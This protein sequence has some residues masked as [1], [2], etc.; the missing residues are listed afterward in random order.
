MSMKPFI[1]LHVHSPFSFLDG[2]S[3]L[4]ALI[5]RAAQLE[6]PA[7]ALTDH[8]NLHG[9]VQFQQL[10]QKA[11]IK[12][13]LGVEMTLEGDYHLTLLAQGPA[14]YATLCT[15]LTKA[16]LAHPRGQPRLK[17]ELLWEHNRGLICLSG[18]RQGL[19]PRLIMEGNFQEAYRI[20]CRFRDRLEFFYLELPNPL[21]PGG[22]RLNS[23][24][25]QLGEEAKIPLVA[26]NN[27]HYAC[28]EDFPLHDV[29]T[30][31]RTKTTLEA[32]HPQ[33]KLNGENYLQST[34]EMALLFPSEALVNTWEIGCR[35]QPALDLSKK[36]FPR[37][38]DF[39]GD[40][41][42]ELV[43]A[44]AQRRY[45][46]ITPQISRRLRHELDIIKQLDVADY[47]LIVWDVAQ[48]ARREGIRYSG[49]G[50]AADSA[51][52]YCLGIT[53]V[54]AIG[55]GLLFERFLSLERAQTPDIDLDFDA[56][57]RDQI[58]D[59]V[60]TKF[61]E[62]F[63]A[64]VCT[65]QTFRARSAVREVGAALGWPPSE[66]QRLAKAL[67]HIPADALRDAP[68]RYPELRR[69]PWSR[70]EKLVSLC[71]RI[72]GFPR[73]VGTHLGGLIIGDLPLMELTPLQ[74]SAKGV[75]ITQYDKDDCEALGFIKL[76]LLSLRTLSA[77]EDTVQAI[78]LREEKFDYSQIPMDDSQTFQMIREGET[79]GVFQLESPA[80]RSLQTRLGADGLEDIIASVALIRPG[81]IKA[82]MVEPFVARRHG[83]EK[84]DYLHPLLE[85]IL[86]KTYG[87][88]LFQ[89]Q[90]IEIAIEVAG[91]TPGEADHLRKIMGK[92]RTKG[93]LDNLRELFITK[94]RQRGLT[95]TRA[96]EIFEYIAAYA[97]YGFCEAHA[98][99]FANLAYKTA[100]LAAHY[101]AEFFAAL[102]SHQPMG[103]YPPQTI[104]L[105]AKRRGIKLLPVDVNFSQGDFFP[106][107]KTI[108]L[109]LRQVKE[110]S[111]EGVAAILE[112]RREGPFTDLPDLVRRT[113]LPRN[114][115]TNLILCGALD[116]LHP[117]RKAL[118]WQLQRLP[119]GGL[120]WA[121]PLPQIE[122]FSPYQKFLYEYSL[123]G[124]SC[125]GHIL[126][127]LRPELKKKGYL[128]H[129]D[130]PTLAAGTKV[131]IA[132]LVIRPH[133]PPTKSGRTVVFLTLEDEYGLID[134]T[135]FEDIYW[136]YG[137][138]I[139]TKPLLLVTGVLQKRGRGTNII[140][141]RLEAL[142]PSL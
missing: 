66:I 60:Y 28:K 129:R 42:E 69:L 41:L 81:P 18:C 67:P 33:R 120:P 109:S 26:T 117:N 45:G 90:V 14:G 19:I 85:P 51:V 77:I 119:A 2:A 7:L 20:A 107:G 134:V 38:G 46:R 122:D 124:M 111:Q 102:L 31:I 123:L 118:L 34:E 114:I 89:E 27:V 70:Y 72:A 17:E 130:L 37:L 4:E 40:R 103:F 140:A 47:F 133:R 137:E 121:A 73:F 141:H 21:L 30:C 131:Q 98:A 105:E 63:V 126:S 101:P 22:K 136:R 55:R 100:Y 108:R 9:A 125:N 1:H 79:V 132:G 15:L 115:V 74:M 116:G 128:S 99:S 95:T 71:E 62:D 110:M 58:A 138:I 112:A 54:D 3:P 82:D 24:L 97:G 11:G 113:N 104:A 127:F 50:S 44:G 25:C 96:A 49:R 52:A 68:H 61:G 43:W 23:L 76:D 93:E 10:A 92:L 139:F 86:A 78:K 94:A 5:N 32:V 29:L 142:Q 64:S 75:K 35:C 12:P 8:D 87:V 83:E 84:V 13:I 16:H 65:F 53:D 59:Y 56:R 80:Q 36:H 106:Q 135:V 39:S 88:V 48:Y 57:Y 6:M 91:F